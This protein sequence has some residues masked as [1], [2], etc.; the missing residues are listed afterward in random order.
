M[1]ILAIETSGPRGG[2]AL[3]EG[4]ADPLSPPRIV[5]EV[6]LAEGLRHGRDLVLAAKEACERA[7]W[8]ARGIPLVAVSIGPGSFTGIRIAVVVAKFLALETGAKI[9]AVPSFRALAANAPAEKQRIVTIVDAKRGGLFASIFERNPQ[10]PSKP[11][12][13]EAPGTAG[14][15]PAMRGACW[16]SSRRSSAPP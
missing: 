8:D 4:G 7:G 15:S 2:I 9:V 10:A 1:R 5:Q 14:G 13:M 6:R 16:A 11:P 12:V 3:A